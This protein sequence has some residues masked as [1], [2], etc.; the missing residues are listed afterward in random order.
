MTPSRS[1][2]PDATPG[3]T[4]PTRRS[5]ATSPFIEW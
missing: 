1:R 5:P 4:S 3:H 2:M